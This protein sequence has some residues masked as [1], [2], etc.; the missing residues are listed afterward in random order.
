MTLKLKQPETTIIELINSQKY[1]TWEVSLIS[2][3][4][5]WKIISKIINIVLPVVIK[6]PST[7]WINLSIDW[8]FRKPLKSSFKLDFSSHFLSIP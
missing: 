7:I 1:N 4:S 8:K 6:I 5:Q 2:S 3:P